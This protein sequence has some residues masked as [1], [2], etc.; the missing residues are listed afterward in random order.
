MADIRIMVCSHKRYRMPADDVYQ[1][2]FGGAALAVPGD[3]PDT[4]AR[5]DTGD[6][7]SERNPHFCEL[8]VLYWGWKNLACKYLGLVH[9]RRY[10][11]NGTTGRDHFDSVLSA[12]QLEELLR[13]HS[14]IVPRKRRYFIETIYSHYK[15]T[16][17]AAQLDRTREII[18]KSCPAYLSS[19]DRIMR[20]RSAYMF[21]MMIMRRD[22]MDAYC[23]W[24]FD[25]LFSLEKVVDMDGLSA[26][27]GRFFGRIS[28]ILFNVWLEQQSEE[29]LLD[30][31]DIAEMPCIYMERV[32]WPGK[33]SAFLN[34][35]FFG[36]KY[37]GSF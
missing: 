13:E 6:N 30:K 8:T 3:I 10:L 27:Q 12:E 17:Y 7:I 14:V 34:A 5:D 22:L 21:N 19:F 31:K 16:H 15:H 9:Y 28:E 26:Y 24:L 33:I 11:G 1:A 25:I 37:E 23:T 36:K 35:K 32:N 29:K 20:R 4:F 2:V 18:A